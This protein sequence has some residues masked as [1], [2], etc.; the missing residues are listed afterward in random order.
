MES[1]IFKLA[2]NPSNRRDFKQFPVEV[3]N[4][5]FGPN[6]RSWI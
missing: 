2:E 4:G 3:L 1:C 5:V 6:K